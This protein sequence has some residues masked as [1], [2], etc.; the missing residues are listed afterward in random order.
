MG[1]NEQA[2]MPAAGYEEFPHVAPQV[3]VIGR[4]KIWMGFLCRTCG[5]R[6]PFPSGT[7]GN[8]LAVW[9][10]QEHRACGQGG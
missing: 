3:F 9:F 5:V 7:D 2:T 10:L 4:D 8:L 6:M 1:A